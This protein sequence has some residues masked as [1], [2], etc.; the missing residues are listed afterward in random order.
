MLICWL[1][2]LQY[3]A[4]ESGCTSMP[5][6]I[7]SSVFSPLPQSKVGRPPELYDSIATPRWIGF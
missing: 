5:Q 4:V 3:Q 7:A 2:W 6:E 1:K